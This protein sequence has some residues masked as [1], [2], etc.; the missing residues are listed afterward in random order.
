MKNSGKEFG[1][2]AKNGGAAISKR[3]KIAD[4]L[5][6]LNYYLQVFGNQNSLVQHVDYW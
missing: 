2:G 3:T 6:T 4:V 1:M 5:S